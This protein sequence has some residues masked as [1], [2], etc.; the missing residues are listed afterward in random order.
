MVIAKEYK[1]N[2]CGELRQCSTMFTPKAIIQ[3]KRESLNVLLQ[4]N[5]LL[6]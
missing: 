2:E 4:I 3:H 5:Y 1:F 6:L